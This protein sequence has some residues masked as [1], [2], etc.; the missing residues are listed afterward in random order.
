MKI[1]YSFTHKEIYLYVSGTFEGVEAICKHLITQG[2]IDPGHEPLTWHRPTKSLHNAA[3]KHKIYY[4]PLNVAIKL[5][6]V[7]YFYCIS[8]QCNIVKPTVALEQK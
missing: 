3:F 8:T 4:F 2:D 5:N 6:I 1:T 7:S